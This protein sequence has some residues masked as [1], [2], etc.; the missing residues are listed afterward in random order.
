M[1]NLIGNETWSNGKNT[2]QVYQ[3]THNG[4]GN[5][6]PYMAKSFISFTFG[7]KAIEDFGLIVVNSSDR[8]E[9]QAYASFSDLTTNYDTLDGQLYWGSRFEP[10]QLELSLATDE[11]TEQQIDDFREWFAPGKERELILS[12]HP[13]RA[14]L[15]RVASA[16]A[17]SFIPFEK[18]TSIKINNLNYDTSTT[19]Y[20]GEVSLSFVM[21]EPHWYGILNY[22]PTYLNKQT[23]EELTVDSNNSNKVNSLQDKDMI[24]IMLEDGIPHQSILLGDNTSTFFL[25]GNILVTGKAVVGQAVV[26][27]AR[28]GIITETSSG[29]TVNSTTPQYLFYSGTASN[30]PIIKFTLT[31]TFNFSQEVFDDEMYVSRYISSPRNSYTSTSNNS[32]ISIDQNKFEFTTPSLMTGIN[33]ACYIFKTVPWGTAL[34]DLKKMIIN[35]VNEYYSRAWALACINTLQEKYHID[36]LV[37]TTLSNSTG[38]NEYKLFLLNNLMTMI[39]SVNPYIDSNCAIHTTGSE[40]ALSQIQSGLQNNTITTNP[41]VFVFN[42]KTGEAIG[43]FTIKRSTDGTIEHFETITIEENVGDMVRSNYLSI[44]GRNY[45]NSSGKLLINNC[46]KI[47]SNENLTDVLVFFKNMYL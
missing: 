24:K 3:A 6:L 30:K 41:V 22:M 21:D 28:I 37:K 25:G 7:G 5:R 18:K 27:E 2:S 45:L 32:F 29:L 15:A 8:M 12:E 20:R 14:I 46:H 43:K 44:E 23:L 35:E 47:I 38:K 4:A 26:N 19:V 10:N 40:S 31:P 13:N 11:I 17:L 16:P 42:S 36:T 9:R 34:V 1:A 39:L 33:K